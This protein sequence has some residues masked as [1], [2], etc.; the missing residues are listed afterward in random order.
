MRVDAIERKPSRVVV[1]RPSFEMS[2]NAMSAEIAQRKD[3]A[4]RGT[5][6][7]RFDVF[8][9]SHWCVKSI[10]TMMI[11]AFRRLRTE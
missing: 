4:M 5:M 7:S 1:T 10:G 11:A 3:A 8:K 2:V 6:Y 9:A